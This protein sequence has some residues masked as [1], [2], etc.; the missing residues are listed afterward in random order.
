MPR[1]IKLQGERL[2][3]FELAYHLKKTVEEL[4]S[5]ITYSEFLEWQEF[6]VVERDRNTKEHFYLAQI[7]AEVRR[8][9]V[10]NPNKIKLADFVLRFA[11]PEEADTENQED[12]KKHKVAVSKGAWLAALHMT[13]PQEN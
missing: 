11:T 12:L 9:M 2:A 13:I 10:K 5:L 3:W 6:L 1:K 7:A 8:S 4:Q